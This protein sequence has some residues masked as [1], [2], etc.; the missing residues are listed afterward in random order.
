MLTRHGKTWLVASASAALVAASAILAWLALGK[1]DIAFLVDDARAGWIVFPTPSD[2]NARV[3]ESPACV[4][5]RA[6]RAEYQPESVTLRFRALRA[7]EVRLNGQLID[8]PSDAGSWKQARTVA[9]EKQI[10]VGENTIEFRVHNPSGP[11]ALCA[12]IAF[13]KAVIGTDTE[14]TA[15][16][17][18][19][20]QGAAT[21][22]ASRRAASR[23]DPDHAAPSLFD[24]L[25]RSWPLTA[26]CLGVGVVVALVIDRLCRR[27]DDDRRR[28]AIV[29]GALG[30]AA[31]LWVILIVHNLAWLPVSVGFDAPGHLEYIEH[32]RTTGRFPLAD[33][34]VQAYHPPLYHAIA[35]G[36]L[37]T[38]SAGATDP[39][40]I[41]A[42]RLLNLAFAL[43]T[44]AAAYASLRLLFPYRL[45]P[46]LV[47][48][49]LAGFL[50]AMLY[51]FHYPTNETL[52]TALAAVVFALCLRIARA[53]RNAHRLHAIAGAALGGAMLAKFSALLL[54][55]AVLLA[56]A[57]QP[58][59]RP[60][61][62]ARAAMRI[63][64]GIAT[65]FAAA[66]VVCGWHYA[67]VWSHFGKP[68]VGNWEP[69]AGLAWWQ[70]PGYH[71]VDDFT[72]FGVAVI[73][74]AYAG[75]RGVWDG[76]YS[77]LFADGL[78]GG[79]GAF[80]V[81]PPWAFD[82][83]TIS[84][85]AGMVILVVLGVGALTVVRRT[86]RE[87]DSAWL[88]A[89][90]TASVTLFAMLAMT[91]VVPSYAQA[92]A[93]YGLVALVPLAAI[94]AAGA[95]ALAGFSRWRRAAVI[96][97]ITAW[98]SLAYA[99]YW[100]TPASRG[101]QAA[102]AA[103]LA[104]EGQP[105]R[106]AEVFHQAINADPDDWEA[107]TG[108]AQLLLANNAPATEILAVLKSDA[109]EPK[110]ARR[111]AA[112]ALA[113]F[114]AGD[115]KRALAEATEG[116]KID[117]DALEPRL[118]RLFIQRAT[119]NNAGALAAARDVLRVDPYNTAIRE[120]L[121]QLKRPAST[122]APK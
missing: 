113:F 85:A 106:A 28:L 47:G 111:S 91:L 82:L 51:L 25:E 45:V 19:A 121:A 44:L 84:A 81:R 98:A 13:P 69:I 22:A 11:P 27:G 23:I 16:F 46:Q 10:R 65:V 120:Q 49:W 77:T 108:L 55:P 4:F 115:T 104:T 90:L 71:T 7:A 97:A 117:P 122:T 56:V 88:L 79:A 57:L 5:R 14:W 76:F 61:P 2:A 60:L 74:P 112:L 103:R 68:I 53:E 102:F 70:D 62:R 83:L 37:R 118:V 110:L 20:V 95:D 34:G 94:A 43:V 107:R 87:A 24:A 30:A 18:D 92:K 109:V 54:V 100:T 35:A 93:I 6:F 114:R 38:I 12:S 96:A 8:T 99:G 72:V 86:L 17:T 119:N 21:F 89:L 101:M 42:I 64:L 15:E 9:I 1:N 73:R 52:A 29:R 39:A 48:I 3:G 78:A 75:F 41:N 31:I 80:N 105:G 116:E 36:V 63:A 66:L 67:R 40:G 26:G 32:I 33:E 58:A 50:P 59:W